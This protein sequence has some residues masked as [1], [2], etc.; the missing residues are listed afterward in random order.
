VFACSLAIPRPGP[1]GRVTDQGLIRARGRAGGDRDLLGSPVPGDRRPAAGGLVAHLPDQS[2]YNR[3]LRRLTPYITTAQLTVAELIADGQV[4]L[5]DGTLLACANYPGCASKSA[6]AG[7]ASYG[8][9][10]S[11][12]LYVSGPG[13]RAHRR[14]QGRPRRR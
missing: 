14:R 10:P 13:A 7:H 9:C 5:L 12:S 6:F 1:V 3:R 4:R 2:Q 8:S 11:K